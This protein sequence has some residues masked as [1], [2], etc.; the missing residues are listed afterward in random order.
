MSDRKI[1][2]VVLFVFG[3]LLNRSSLCVGAVRASSLA[4]ETPQ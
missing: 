3:V 1:I 4:T 2:A